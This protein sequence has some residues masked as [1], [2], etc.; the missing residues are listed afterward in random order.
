MGSFF[1]RKPNTTYNCLYYRVLKCIFNKIQNIHMKQLLFFSALVIG[2]CFSFGQTIKLEADISPGSNG[3][4]SGIDIPLIYNGAFYF[5]ANDGTNGLELWMH[6]GNTASLIQDLSPGNTHGNP[7]DLTIYNGELYF[8]A[9]DGVNGGELWKYNGTSFSLVQ[10]INPSGY[11]NP[12]EITEYN[13][14]LYFRA[15]DGTNGTE[16]W[17]YDGTS[18][19]LVQDINPG[20]GNSTPSNLKVFNGELFFTAN[21]GTNGS[22]LWKY[23][24]TTVSLVQDIRTGIQS[25]APSSFTIFNGNLVFTANDGTNGIE[26]W[27]YNGI[28][29]SLISDI[30]PGVSNSSPQYFTEY[31]GELIF[32]AYDATNGF[33]LWKYDGT[34]ASLIMDINPGTASG[35]PSFFTE[36]N[37]ELYFGANDGVNG[38]ELW[39][40]NGTTCS[41]AK[42]STVGPN[43]A[44]PSYLIVYNEELFFRGISG[45]FAS[46]LMKYDGD[47]ITLVKDIN[48]GANSSNPD[49]FFKFD[50]R[51]FFRANDGVHGQ[52][53]WSYS[54]YT[55][56]TINTTVCDSL[57]SPSGDSVWFANGTYY[58]TVNDTAYTINLTINQLDIALYVD[59]NTRCYGDSNGGATVTILPPYNGPYSFIW[60][61]GDTLPYSSIVNQPAGELSVKV[62]DANGCYKRDTVTITQPDSLT[63]S[64]TLDSNVS[65]N[66]TTDGGATALHHGGNYPYNYSWSNGG[67][68]PT[69]TNVP[70]GTYTV[71]VT[72]YWGCTPA[73][74]SI[75][76]I[77]LNPSSVTIYEIVCDSLVSPSGNFTWTATGIYKDTIPN[78]VGCDSVMTFDLTVNHPSASTE[79]RIICQGDSTIIGG[80]WYYND[81]IVNDTLTNSKL[82]DSVI[83]ITVTK[84]SPSPIN[85]GVD[86]SICHNDSITISA[87]V[88]DSYL[89]NNGDTTASIVVKGS[90]VG[91]GTNNYWVE[92]TDTNGCI[93]KDTI[94]V[95]ITQCSNAGI[96]E[97][98]I[99]NLIAIYPNP[100]T[101]QSFTVNF[102]SYEEDCIIEIL[103]VSGKIIKRINRQNKSIINVNLTTE[104]GIY[105][106]KFISQNNE[107]GVAKIVKQ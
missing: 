90:I 97:A 54:P 82:C 4:I 56:S 17:K 99:H 60:S 84:V 98:L 28:S 72:D 48:I 7:Q 24:G 18:A 8:G 67:N 42:E 46:E 39:K 11:S 53:L 36:F 41:L 78:A 29:T 43:G 26:L 21:D 59:S 83:T 37:G 88:Y 103:D 76:I 22:E 85:L 51:L 15:D 102:N 44:Y 62:I 93:S 64:I 74:D 45:S 100:I 68:S 14:E 66:G 77:K 96:N 92:A 27:K 35:Q 6:N 57:I 2:S 79:S 16:L 33:E 30:N 40:Y 20:T 69:I 10:D 19:F 101:E 58:D 31:N 80:K 1:Y 87:G 73:V 34:S 94:T 106:V 32:T 50:N 49:L 105:F 63:V 25:S 12:R 5:K 86:T 70:T 71:T 95:T 81:T 65:C 9:N 107:I 13:G 23:N 75:T 3:G 61:T 104:K 52:E 55:D 89:W 47:T 91:V 38:G